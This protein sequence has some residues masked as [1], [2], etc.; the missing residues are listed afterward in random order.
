MVYN[1]ELYI[2]G[3]ITPSNPVQLLCRESLHYVSIE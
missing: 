3:S 1:I 2:Y